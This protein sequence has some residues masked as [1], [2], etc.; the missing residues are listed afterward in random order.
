M[1][2]KN[3]KFDRLGECGSEKDCCTRTPNGLAKSHFSECVDQKDEK[4]VGR[5]W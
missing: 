1:F 2:S 3:I 4:E 5:S